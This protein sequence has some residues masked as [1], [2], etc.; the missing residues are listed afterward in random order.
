MQSIV[1]DDGL[2]IVLQDVHRWQQP[3]EILALKGNFLKLDECILNQA[4]VWMSA[5]VFW[6]CSFGEAPPG[7]LPT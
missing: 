5:R 2:R 6:V 1:C 4:K 3:L 7:N